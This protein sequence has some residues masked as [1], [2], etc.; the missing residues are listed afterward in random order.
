MKQVLRCILPAWPI[1]AAALLLTTS[2]RGAE[3]PRRPNVLFLFSDDQ[4]ADTVAALGNSH[5]R[6]PNLDRL[7]RQGT[8]CTRTYCMGALQG[9]VCVPSRAMVMS[10]RTLFRVHTDLADQ[11][12]WPEAFGKAG[13]TTFM[14]GK[15]H[16]GPESARRCFAEGK[17]VFF[18]GMGDP[19]KLPVQ[20]FG[21][22]ELGE[23]HPSGKHSV[24]LFADSAVDFLKRQ[25]G[26]K[27]FLCYVAF[28]APHDPRLA[29]KEYHDPYNADKPPLPPNFLPVHPFNNGDLVGRDAEVLVVTDD[30]ADRPR[31]R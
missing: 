29:P 24:E 8:A 10:G 23:P 18:G 4:R 31:R 22:K 28:N 14:T 5:I 2:C 16:N 1:F 13:Y 6:T 25:Q 15:W 11:E 7:V 30:A 27:P 20:D 17:A 3:S 12:T 9:A 26:G 21:P 19:Y